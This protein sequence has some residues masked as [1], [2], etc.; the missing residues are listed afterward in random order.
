MDVWVNNTFQQ[1]FNVTL[2]VHVGLFLFFKYS[3]LKDFLRY[4]KEKIGVNLGLLGYQEFPIENQFP[5]S[6]ASKIS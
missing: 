6:I 3:V 4:L 2:Y 5:M 1:N